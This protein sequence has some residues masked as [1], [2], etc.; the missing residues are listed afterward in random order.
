MCSNEDV[1][2]RLTHDTPSEA[3]EPLAPRAAVGAS[4]IRVTRNW[5]T[6]SPPAERGTCSQQRER[7]CTR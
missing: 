7:S 1:V 6:A 4:V 5:R 3:H 2:W